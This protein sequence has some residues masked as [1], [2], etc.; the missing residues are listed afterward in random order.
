MA[1]RN[2]AFLY[3]N[4][5]PW[6]PLGLAVPNWGNDE[7][8]Q[9]ETIRYLCDI[10]GRNLQSLMFHDD[11]RLRVP[12]SIN[13]LTRIHKLCTRARSILV[14]RAVPANRENMESA[15]ANPSPERRSAGSDVRSLRVLQP[16]HVLSRRANPPA[17]RLRFAFLSVGR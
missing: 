12:P 6:S 5:P 7:Q 4:V 10:L 2:D 15:H 11:A 8:S 3:Y 17:E 13:T 1:F 9:N 14:S 16:G